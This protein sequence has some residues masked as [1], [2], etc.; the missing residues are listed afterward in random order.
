MKKLTALLLAAL[1]AFA[2]LPA[3]GTAGVPAPQRDIPDP[4][5]LE[6]YV[7]GDPEGNLGGKWVGFTAELP[8]EVTAF[9]SGLTTYAAAYTRGKVYGYVYGYNAVGDLCDYFYVMNAATHEISY[10]EGASSGGVFVYG[11][12][13]NSADRTM[14]ALCDEDHPY[15]AR[16][17]LLTGALTKVVDVAL[18]SALGLQTFAIDAGG[19]FYALTFSAVSSK[20]VRINIS[21]GALTEVLN[22]GL[23]CFYAQSMTYDHVTNSI[24]W[25]Q[26]DS[27]TSLSNGL[28]RIDMDGYALSYCGMI[29]TNLELMALYTV[30]DA[31]IEFLL[32][33]AD[34]DGD[35]DSA[36]ALLVLR[37][38]MGIAFIEDEGL[39]AADVNENG[40]ID[41]ADAL[42]I[43]RASMGLI[44]L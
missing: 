12:A 43:L 28:Y 25:A 30:Y 40:V 42:M 39:L 6:G 38:S 23:P 11:M 36:D 41:S 14:Y 9:G 2:A 33:D 13:F 37:W 17:D 16:V 29:G 34:L 1:L 26:V 15:I 5:Y 44:E 18:G 35:V 19:S 7:V 10:P 27:Q 3:F 4:I 32:G 8:S 22:T 31:P 20:L 21:T 24:Y